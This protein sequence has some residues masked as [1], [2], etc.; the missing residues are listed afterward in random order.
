VAQQDGVGGVSPGFAGDVTEG[1][2]AKLR[3][4]EPHLVPGVEKRA[5][6]GKQAKGRQMLVWDAA[7]NG[8]VW[9]VDQ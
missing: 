3:V 4:E 7:A 5:A 2:G 1:H 8:R 9:R 6:Q